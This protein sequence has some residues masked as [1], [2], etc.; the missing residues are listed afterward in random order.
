MP[1]KRVTKRLKSTSMRFVLFVVT[2]LAIAASCAPAGSE[3]MRTTM[4]R[5]RWHGTIGTPPD[6]ASVFI[7]VDTIGGHRLIAEAD[8]PAQAL[9][10][11]PLEVELAR[12]TLRFHWSR[13]ALDGPVLSAITPPL[14]D[15]MS[16]LFSQGGTGSP[17][18]LTRIGPPRIS[19]FLRDVSRG[20]SNGRDITVLSDGAGPLREHF[21]A[22][23]DKVRLL[24][25]LSPT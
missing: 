4:L 2:L 13:A 24:L 3:S 20:A 5:G 10:D 25:L 6:S 21:N 16:A 17:L 9:S 1:E 19:D 15:T 7:D 18:R 11:F 23:S 8:I 22:N 14:G 12:D